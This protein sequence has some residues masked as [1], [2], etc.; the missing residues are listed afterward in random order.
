MFSKFTSPFGKKKPVAKPVAKRA[1]KTN[2]SA[3]KIA[4]RRAAAENAIAPE[5]EGK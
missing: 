2:T 1:V 3:E 5:G 4:T